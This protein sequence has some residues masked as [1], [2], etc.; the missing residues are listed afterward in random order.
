MFR[1]VRISRRGQRSR[2][3]AMQ[4]NTPISSTRKMNPKNRRP[5][6]STKKRS[7][8]NPGSL[9]LH[10]DFVDEEAPLENGSC[11]YDLGQN[12]GHSQSLFE[13]RITGAG[14]RASTAPNPIQSNNLD[15]DIMCD[16]HQF[17]EE[18]RKLQKGLTLTERINHIPMLSDCHKHFHA[19]RFY[20]VASGSSGARCASTKIF[21][22]AQRQVK[23]QGNGTKSRS[24]LQN[25]SS[26]CLVEITFNSSRYEMNAEVR[27]RNQEEIRLFLSA[28]DLKEL[29][30]C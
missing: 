27:C 7:G 1:Y 16:P 29:F 28:L 19:R 30:G 20:V 11:D 26:R 4:E 14:T 21:V 2:Q 6:P 23:A 17:S 9:R 3:R 13:T 25:A 24:L 5:L 8:R 18:W 12:P 10:V 15:V 22:I